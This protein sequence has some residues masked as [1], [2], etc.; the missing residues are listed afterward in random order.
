[1]MT[2]GFIFYASFYQAVTCLSDDD[3][4]AAYD[5]ICGYAITGFEPEQTTGAAY[6]VY[7]MAKPQIDKNRARRENGMR[8]GRPKTERKP[9]ENQTETK[10]EPTHY[11]PET[12]LEAKE[13]DK[14]KVKVKEKD[15]KANA[16]MPAVFEIV[17]Y[18]N[19]KAGTKYRASSRTTAQLIKA[20]LEEHYTVSDFKRVIDNKTAE[21]L[22]TEQAVYLRPETLFRP[23]HFESYLNQPTPQRKTIKF[24]NFPQRSDDENADLVR[25]VIAMQ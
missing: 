24:A 19:E 12:I 1:M 22:N 4:L 2:D 10:D 13:K 7:L 6:A 9:N 5:M 23:A 15:N 3:R 14:D 16:L 8:G 25:K 18:L 11:A 21:W 20:R 17:D